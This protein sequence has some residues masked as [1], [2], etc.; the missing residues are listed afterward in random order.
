MSI[1]SNRDAVVLSVRS[2]QNRIPSQARLMAFK[3]GITALEAD[4]AAL[5]EPVNHKLYRQLA[6]LERFLDDNRR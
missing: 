1:P 2:L 5:P 3:A 4:L 6:D